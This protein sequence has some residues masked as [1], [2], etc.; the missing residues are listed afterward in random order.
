MGD[1]AILGWGSLIWDLDDLTPHV[2]GDWDIG[3]G[4]VLPMEFTRISPKRKM[5]LVVCLDPMHGV[6][7]ATHAITS[8]RSGITEA[9]GDLA[10]RERAPVRRIG[11]VCLASG[12]SNGSSPEVVALIADWCAQRGKTGAVWTDLPS[13]FTEHLGEPFSVLR[14][15]DYLGALAG[16]S[17]DEAVRYIEN[18]PA[19]TDTPLRRAL[20]AEPWWQAEARRLGLR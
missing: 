15:L 3:A 8:V 11:A 12:H 19:S 7:C 20:A 2:R 14:A 17:R 18:A 10:R 1:Y 16:A 5:G 13:N 9:A 4:P 6:G